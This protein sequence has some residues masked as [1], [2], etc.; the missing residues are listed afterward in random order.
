MPLFQLR[1]QHRVALERAAEGQFIRDVA[2]TIRRENHNA[3]WRIQDLQFQRMVAV[4][5]RRARAHGLLMNTAI[6]MFVKLMFTV[7]PNFDEQSEVAAELSAGEGTPEERL[8]SLRHVVSEQ[9]WEEAAR[10]YRSAAWKF[11]E[12]VEDS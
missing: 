2:L 11:S 10:L 7:S 4:G 12:S 5:V 1:W 6:T 8:Y 9:A 3:V